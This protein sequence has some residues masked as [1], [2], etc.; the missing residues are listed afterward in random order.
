MEQI[1]VFFLCLFSSLRCTFCLS[2]KRWD[3]GGGVLGGRSASPPGLSCRWPVTYEQNR[4]IRLRGC[5][6]QER[7]APVHDA[8]IKLKTKANLSQRVPSSLPGMHRAKPRVIYE[9]N[10]DGGK[11]TNHVLFGTRGPREFKGHT[12][13]QSN[14]RQTG[15]GIRFL[16]RH[17][18]STQLENKRR[19]ACPAGLV[20]M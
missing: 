4:A 9:K 2:R 13:G 5:L 20:Q 8:Y 19:A 16:S 18:K 1:A 10:T 3:G 11:N 15:V 7:N 17:L 12:A 14:R 6:R